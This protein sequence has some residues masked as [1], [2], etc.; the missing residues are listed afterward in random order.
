M[1]GKGSKPRPLAVPYDEYAAQYEAIFAKRK[2]LRGRRVV[3][4][5]GKR[6]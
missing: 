2:L 3:L 5:K 4:K 6:P 1:S